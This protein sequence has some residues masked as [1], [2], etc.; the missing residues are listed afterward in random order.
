MALLTSQTEALEAQ[1]HDT[2]SAGQV[3]G[4]MENYVSA[5]GDRGLE[6]YQRAKT[7]V[8]L[9]HQVR[10]A[11]STMVTATSELLA[12]LTDKVKGQALLA[13]KGAYLGMSRVSSAIPEVAEATS[14][15]EKHDAILTLREAMV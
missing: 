14:A 2:T 5:E 7:A 8:Q 6:V 9:H 13:A 15:L 10:T 11:I 4:A 1:V 3:E 12:A